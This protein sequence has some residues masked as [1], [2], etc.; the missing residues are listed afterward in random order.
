MRL[1]TMRRPRFE[2]PLETH[3]TVGGLT[4][5]H[6]GSLHVALG[7][8]AHDPRQRALDSRTPRSSPSA[9]TSWLRQ[10]IGQTDY[11]ICYGPAG[12]TGEVTLS[13]KQKGP[14]P[15]PV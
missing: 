9:P 15:K 6:Q 1:P 2:R 7:R 4:L 10:T 5:P 13:L 12:D 8:A 3:V 14:V 11:W